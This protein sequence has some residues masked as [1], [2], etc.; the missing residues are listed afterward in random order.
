MYMI[1]VFLS[2]ASTILFLSLDDTLVT[3]DDVVVPVPDGCTT[4]TAK[5]TPFV[6]IVFL[7]GFE[8]VDTRVSAEAENERRLEVD[9]AGEFANIMGVEDC[10]AAV[11]DLKPRMDS[12]AL[13]R[14]D[15]LLIVYSYAICA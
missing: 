6:R 7:V 15:C 2:R 5:E 13:R 3:C 14:G 8:V 4:D 10:T 12:K 1:S 11:D 9:C